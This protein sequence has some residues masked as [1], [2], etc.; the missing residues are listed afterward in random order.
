MFCVVFQIG[1]RWRCSSPQIQWGCSCWLFAVPSDRDCP[2]QPTKH[3]FGSVLMLA[4]GRVQNKSWCQ[5]PIHSPHQF[6][7]SVEWQ[8]LRIVCRKADSQGLWSPNKS[9]W[10]KVSLFCFF[11]HER[12]LLA[13]LRSKQ[14]VISRIMFEFFSCRVDY[15]RP[16]YI[17]LQTSKVKSV[18]HL[19]H[20]DGLAEAW[21]VNQLLRH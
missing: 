19:F 11:W 15:R 8:T 10:G 20:S 18:H 17:L 1:S 14:L 13:Y 16:S 5:T 6:V 12:S 4:S 2:D 21:Y 3:R 7:S 9:W